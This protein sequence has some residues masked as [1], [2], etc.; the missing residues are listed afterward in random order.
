M[1]AHME[2]QEMILWQWSI[3]FT[4]LFISRS[5][6]M[7]KRFC[8]LLFL[9]IISTGCVISEPTT[10]TS[11]QVTAS[12]EVVSETPEVLVTTPIDTTRT[13]TFT[14]TFFPTETVVTLAPTL[15]KSQSSV[16][17]EDE[18]INFNCDLF[19]QQGLVL[20]KSKKDA[21]V[22]LMNH[23]GL[24]FEEGTECTPYCYLTAY[25]QNPDKYELYFRFFFS[26][27]EYLMRYYVLAIPYRY[28]GMEIEDYDAKEIYSY[29]GHPDWVR[30][31]IIPYENEAGDNEYWMSWAYESLNV[32]F[33]FQG[34]TL[35][36]SP[37][38]YVTLCPTFNDDLYGF[39]MLKMTHYPDVETLRFRQ[40]MEP[41]IDLSEVTSKS[42][43]DIFQQGNGHIQ[44]NCFDADVSEWR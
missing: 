36:N 26:D 17:I 3:H 41:G 44:V 18:I 25:Y 34:S 30:I 15:N 32:V 43:S 37:S 31:Y 5:K 28:S 20:G 27:E 21:V 2:M 16:K 4:S 22:E 11:N 8:M 35:D 9:L 23:L 6:N 12:K 1:M 19:C 33:T 39:D 24:F 13:A 10:I 38:N 14:P 40:N 7:K 42:F 29:L